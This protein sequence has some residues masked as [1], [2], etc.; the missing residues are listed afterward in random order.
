MT[1]VK[2]GKNGKI[3]KRTKLNFYS[4]TIDYN[5]GS[6]DLVEELVSF[7]PEESVFKYTL[8]RFHCNHKLHPYQTDSILAW[9]NQRPC[10][11]T[12][13]IN[14]EDITYLI[15]RLQR[16]KLWKEQFG[17]INYKDVTLPFLKNV[18]DNLIRA[19]ENDELY[20]KACAFLEIGEMYDIGYVHPRLPH[21]SDD[22]RRYRWLLRTSS[23]SDKSPIPNTQIFTI[24][25]RQPQKWEHF[26]YIYVK[27]G[28]IYQYSN[29]LPYNELIKS[30]GYVCLFDLL[31]SFM[32][33]NRPT[34]HQLLPIKKI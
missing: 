13:P 15:P 2:E 34:L 26:R 12:N 10:S 17:D 8:V 9:M 32:F 11:F 29:T 30:K 27:G 28:Y 7:K 33:I 19:P 1:E 14:R 4:D 23:Q 21:L 6:F 24:S 5:Q 22:D 31:K 16:K 3:D 20:E 25:L 18:F